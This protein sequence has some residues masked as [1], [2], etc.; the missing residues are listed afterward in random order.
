[1]IGGMPNRKSPASRPS[2][3]R[4]TPRPSS[5][6]LLKDQAYTKLRNLIS[7]GVF[8][9]NTF[10]SERQLVRQLGMS[11]TPIRSALEQLE[12]RG[13]VAISPQ[14]GIVVKERSIRETVELFD[15]RT[16]IEPFLVSRLA[17]RGLS[18]EQQALAAK[19]LERQ[20]AVANHGD[21]AQAAMLDLEFHMLLAAFHDNRE[22]RDWLSICFDKLH[23]SIRRVNRLMAGRMLKS[24]A[25][26]VAIFTAITA[27]RPELA[28]SRMTDHLKYGRQFL[29][30]S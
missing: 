18:T 4:R 15:V 26:H 2:S 11:K 29:L 8:S 23:E 6:I 1:M 7:T 28:A 19:N 20:K 24:Q 25:D 27:G 9:P 12:L 22:M 10:L 14:Q 5:K 17:T 16:A 13:M 3:A 21:F 30:D